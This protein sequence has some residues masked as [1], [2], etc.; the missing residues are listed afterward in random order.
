[1][2][3]YTK[4]VYDKDNNIIEEQSFEYTG[5]VAQ[6]RKSYERSS[7]GTTKTVISEYEKLKK[8]VEDAKN[9]LSSRS[10]E[11]NQKNLERYE[12]QLKEYESGLYNY[13]TSDKTA[14]LIKELG[15]ETGKTVN[16][17]DLHENIL[18]K[19]ATYNT[20]FTLS[21]LSEEELQDHSF[22]E[23][24]V[25][26]V[27]A[28]SGGIG[29]PTG[30]NV[31]ASPFSGTAAPGFYKDKIVRQAQKEYQD[32][33]ADAVEVLQSGRD[34]FF[35]SVNM[36]STVGPGEERG[37]ADFCKMEF[38]LHEPYGITF[39]E[40][41]R[42]AA[43]LQG[44]LDH[45][46]APMLL[47]IEFKGFDE[48]GKPMDGEGTVR[49]IPILITRVDLDVNEGGAIYD[50]TAVRIND[51]AFDDRFKF[52][53]TNV[54]FSA[55]TLLEA[56]Q[57]LAEQLNDQIK[58]EK[59]EHKVRTVLDE[60]RIEFD[61][62]VLD[63]AQ[64]YVGDKDVQNA[65]GFNKNAG[66][67]VEIDTGE[68]VIDNNTS[69]TKLIED[70]VRQTKG[71]EDLAT[72]LWR[73]Y[74]RRAGA[75]TGRQQ[76][77][78]DEMKKIMTSE[79]FED[80]VTKNPFVDW[81]KIKTSV[82]THYNEPLD[83]INKMHRKTVTYKVIPYKI[84]VLKFLRPGVF[85]AAG[86]ARS[87]VKKQYNYIYTGENNDIQNLR[88]NYKT[89]YYMKNAVDVGK[90]SQGVFEKIDN[91]ITKLIG[92]EDPTKGDLAM[93]RS[94]P[95]AVKGRMVFNKSENDL[96]REARKQD[97]YDYLT[98]PTVDMMRIEMEI[99]GDPAYLC[100]DQFIPLNRDGNQ[101]PTAGRFDTKLGSF[102]VD[103][104]TP[105]IE[106]V[107]VL[108]DD[109]DVNKGIMYAPANQAKKGNRLLFFAGIYQVVR[110]DSSM[111]NN[112]F[113]Q[114]LTCVRLNNQ[115]GIGLPVGIN[116]SAGKYFTDSKNKK[117]SL[118]DNKVPDFLRKNDDGSYMYGG[119]AI[120]KRKEYFAIKDGIQSNEDDQ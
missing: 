34:I 97:F 90:G 48:N 70:M 73:T 120:N 26:D 50:V 20:L 13:R 72:D 29:G 77:S 79:K 107:Y 41:V 110:I 44:Y 93:M 75:I 64:G 68:T 82:E 74:L 56:G 25:H 86:S 14:A 54:A 58:D 53:R 23:N 6:A 91:L 2:K 65:R 15:Q 84:H 104:Y 103:S 78:D 62:R 3:V 102:N 38:K 5:P 43:R 52:P 11:L 81:F 106:L 117:N 59:E 115:E 39:V 47:T 100:Q 92:Q 118:T 60:Y 31:S 89:A 18:H 71:Y 12:K 113:L 88:I 95:S 27:I 87:Q 32:L 8:K 9:G 76:A 42:A 45:L 19:F 112:Q 30:A 80:I 83:L 7:K 4:I 101:Y 85:M 57:K 109:I 37:L 114:T 35:E 33:Y 98:N 46:D 69:V 10:F 36:L 116:S 22:L 67:F 94:Y 55:K 16:G 111:A 40:K 17:A 108:P 28:R 99:L 51:I 119:S 105:L 63:I 61:P 49:K 24:T 96:G 21:G 1:M 66:Q